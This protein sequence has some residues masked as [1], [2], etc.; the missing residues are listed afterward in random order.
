MDDIIF[1]KIIENEI[2]APVNFAD[3][4]KTDWGIL[5]SDGQN[6][7]CISANHAVITDTGA[8]LF[9]A[10]EQTRDFYLS[11]N[12]SPRISTPFSASLDEE[13]VKTLERAGFF[14]EQ[15]QRFKQTEGGDA[16]VS[17]IKRI[18]KNALGD[19]FTDDP[20]RFK[21]RVVCMIKTKP[22]GEKEQ[23][24]FS[25]A[26]ENTFERELCETLFGTDS[27]YIQ[28]TVNRLCK[29]QN[30]R[31]FVGRLFG[32]GAS[33]CTVEEGKEFCR[34]TNVFTGMGFRFSGFAQ[35]TVGF[36]VKEHEKRSQKPL[37]LL[38]ENPTLTMLYQKVGFET[39]A[40]IDKPLSFVW[41]EQ[42]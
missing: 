25:V 19:E 27:E 15:R 35:K 38:T 14:Y 1:E 40:L 26:E 6:P 21:N 4:E 2:Y 28:K 24:H 32:D 33:I 36:A 41:R 31:F 13:Q 34:L 42:K 5:Y 9:K 7:A 23:R 37:Y 20:D 10:A 39:V 12:L 8:D 17:T 30:A 29:S 16:F 18:L 22:F 11:K 3:C